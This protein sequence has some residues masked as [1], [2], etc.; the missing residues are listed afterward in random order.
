M[1]LLYEVIAITNC[2]FNYYSQANDCFLG[3]IDDFLTKAQTHFQC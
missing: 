3:L 1:L 2:Y